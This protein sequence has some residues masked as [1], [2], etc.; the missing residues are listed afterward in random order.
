[1]VST[2][3]SEFYRRTSLRYH[4]TFD[5]FQFIEAAKRKLAPSEPE[6]FKIFLLTVMAGLRRREIDTVE[7]N[8]ERYQTAA[9][10]QRDLRRCLEMWEP[11]GQIARFPVGL[12]DVPD[13]LL[14]SEKLYGRDSEV[15]TLLAAF[16]R[17]ALAATRNG[18]RALNV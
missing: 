4:S 2:F 8:E 3:P 11:S 18:A 17:V 15:D 5:E 7:W 9:G 10:V 12:Q 6:Q 16:D 14:V 13:Q 1:L